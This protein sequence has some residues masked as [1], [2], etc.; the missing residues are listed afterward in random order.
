MLYI[1]PDMDFSRKYLSVVR[2]WENKLEW[3]VVYIM[4]SEETYY[5]PAWFH[6]K[7]EPLLETI[8]YVSRTSHLLSI[9]LWASCLCLGFRRLFQR[10]SAMMVYQTLCLAVT[11]LYLIPVYYILELTA[12]KVTLGHVFSCQL[13]FRLCPIS[14]LISLP[15]TLHSL[16]PDSISVSTTGNAAA[17]S[18]FCSSSAP[19]YVTEFTQIWCWILCKLSGSPGSRPPSFRPAA[20]FVDR[21]NQTLSWRIISHGLWPQA[22]LFNNVTPTR[23]VA[24]FICRLSLYMRPCKYVETTTD[25]FN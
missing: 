8:T 5:R 24:G 10:N 6:L 17:L 14:T 23:P 12:E 2:C 19:S 3:S 4:D 9:K 25:R 1:R 20:V 21:C 16:D 7:K 22:V 15:P 18:C 13:S 11:I